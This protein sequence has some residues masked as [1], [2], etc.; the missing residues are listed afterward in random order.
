MDGVKRRQ[1]ADGRNHDLGLERRSHLDGLG[2]PVRWVAL[3]GVG[4]P[5]L[6]GDRRGG[7]QGGSLHRS[8]AVPPPA[9]GVG[10]TPAA[11]GGA[12][13]VCAV[14]PGGPLLRV[15]GRAPLEGMGG[16]M[17]IGG[18]PPPRPRPTLWGVPQGVPPSPLSQNFFGEFLPATH[19]PRAPV[20]WISHPPRVPFYPASSHFRGA[21]GPKNFPGEFLEIRVPPFARC[22]GMSSTPHAKRGGAYL[23]A[24]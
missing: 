20:A 17:E 18:P 6:D 7:E 1:N 24:R 11:G 4:S 23:N 21:A 14:G 8:P 5:G 19:S 10:V 15:V 9:R 16:P 3:G 13:M 2:H 22:T 12:P